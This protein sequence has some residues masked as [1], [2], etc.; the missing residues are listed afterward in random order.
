MYTLRTPLHWRSSTQCNASTVH[1]PQSLYI[2]LNIFTS[3]N[4]VSNFRRVATVEL[5]HEILLQG[6]YAAKTLPQT[7]DL[8]VHYARDVIYFYFAKCEPRFEKKNDGRKKKKTWKK[9][10]SSDRLFVFLSTPEYADILFVL[11]PLFHIDRMM[12]LL[13]AKSKQAPGHRTD[14]WDVLIYEFFRQK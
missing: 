14:R 8:I 9:H 10:T 6:Y 5:T 3:F 2:A 12:K 11:N 4:W 1:P 13:R 7:V